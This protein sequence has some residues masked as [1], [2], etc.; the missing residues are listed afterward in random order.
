MTFLDGSKPRKIGL[1]L[2]IESRSGGM[3]QYAQS[4]IEA[5]SAIGERYEVTVVYRDANWLPILRRL[6]MRG[7]KLK[8]I[9]FG[10]FFADIA[11][12]F[13]LPGK[14]TRFVGKILNPL[15]R[16]LLVLECDLWIFPAQ[17][18]L[19]YQVPFRPI[20]TIHDLMHRYQSS[21]PEV[22]ANGRY[23]IR[24]HRLKNIAN[25]S[26]GVLVDSELGRRH[27]VESYNS[28]STQVHPLPYIAPSYLRCMVERPDFDTFYKL[29]PKFI[30]YPAQFWSHKNHLRLLDVVQQLAKRFSNIALV[31][32]G[33][34]NHCYQ[35]VK[36]HAENLGIND[37]VRFVGYVPDADMSGFYR[38]A[39]ALV[40][41][42]FFGPTN[43]PP[44]EAMSIGCPVIISGIFGMPEQCGDA[45][46][47]FDPKSTNEMALQIAL[48]WNDD[49]LAFEM[50]RKGLEHI[51]RRGQ[52]QFNQ[53]LAEIIGKVFAGS[54]AS[55]QSL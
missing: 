17:E 18:S 1:F 38:R 19:T 32:S 8:H 16:E 12:V 26:A 40:L 3:F 44:L 39:R 28:P 42:T 9:R 4:L 48:V 14:L 41:P 6:G 36:K 50:S 15:V 20:G 22:G 7:C 23:G 11:T 25:W 2:G 24:E 21:F 5:L 34:Q 45:A 31:L 43:I 29:P 33:G 46:L 49:D 27:V 35:E 53:R 10:M 37:R 47:Y 52:P 54:G 55:A 30:F 13:R 51:Q